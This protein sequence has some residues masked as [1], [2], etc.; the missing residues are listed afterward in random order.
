MIYSSYTNFIRNRLTNDDTIWADMQLHIF[1]AGSTIN[2][3]FRDEYT[4]NHGI[5]FSRCSSV[6][7]DFFWSE[8]ITIFDIFQIW[9]DC[10]SVWFERIFL[11]F[12]FWFLILVSVWFS[13]DF[14]WNFFAIF[15]AFG[16]YDRSR[17]K[18]AFS[19]FSRWITEHHHYRHQL[20]QCMRR[21]N[22]NPVF[23]QLPRTHTHTQA[24]SNRLDDIVWKHKFHAPYS[25][26]R[27][28]VLLS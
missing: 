2:K 5:H 28:G 4:N 16:A 17:S 27:R 3:L 6:S 25:V 12:D 8:I 19:F 18:F 10:I 24:H 13:S 21:Y 20:C 1:Q 9:L 15:H 23:I 11:C 7:L 22:K 14:E 26:S